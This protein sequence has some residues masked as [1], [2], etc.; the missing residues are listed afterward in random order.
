M[1]FFSIPISAEHL[2]QLSVATLIHIIT[3]Q[4]K[5]MGNEFHMLND[6]DEVVECTAEEQKA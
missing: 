1:I 5:S 2:E 3:V 4:N 6:E